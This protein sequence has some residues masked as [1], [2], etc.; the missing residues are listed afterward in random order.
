LL[1]SCLGL[2]SHLEEPD[3]YCQSDDIGNKYLVL[4]D[5]YPIPDNFE[6]KLLSW[7]EEEKVPEKFEK[8]LVDKWEIEHIKK[9]WQ[10]IEFI[11]S[12]LRWAIDKVCPGPDET[13]DEYRKENGSWHVNF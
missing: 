6:A 5:G 8:E 2:D 13:L 1:Q 7:V 9:V 4:Q 10:L 12:V 11:Q 3:P